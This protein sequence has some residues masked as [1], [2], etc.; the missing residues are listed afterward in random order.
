MTRFEMRAAAVVAAVVVVLL[1]V[2]QAQAQA[3]EP[4]LLNGGFEGDVIEHSQ[5]VIVAEE[6]T[7]IYWNRESMIEGGSPGRSAQPEYK[8]LPAAVDSHRVRSGGQSQCWF[9]FYTHGDAAIWQQVRVPAGWY[10]VEAYAQAWVSN[11][12]DQPHESP[13]EMYVSVGLDPEGREPGGWPWETSV[14]WSPFQLVRGQY[15]RV[16]SRPV[17][18]ESDGLLTVYLRAWKKWDSKHG[19]VYWDDARLIE[20]GGPETG[21]ETPAPLPT[22]TPYPT[23]TPLPTAQPCP[24][25]EPGTGGECPGIGEI[26]SVVE[27]VIADRAP[28]RWP[29]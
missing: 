8:P 16:L 6:W 2:L 25:C 24:T 1:A 27:T 20:I 21:S 18:V 23:Y 7:P 4:Q 22:Y 15:E 13:G 29:R 12:D 5:R 11:R 28:V 10:Q 3:S 17:Y 26:R 19:D 9:W 14:V